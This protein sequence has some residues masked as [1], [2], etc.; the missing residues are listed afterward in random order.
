LKWKEEKLQKEADARITK[1]NLR[2][3]E[4]KMKA[5]ET[6][7]KTERDLVRNKSTQRQI[8]A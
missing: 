3:K 5:D 2:Q 7:E 1:E 4:E 8:F 6:K